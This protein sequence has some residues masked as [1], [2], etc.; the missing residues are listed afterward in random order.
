[1]LHSG[2]LPLQSESDR[3][4]DERLPCRRHKEVMGWLMLMRH[5]LMATQ[6]TNVMA[7]T[8][9]MN[10]R[11]INQKEWSNGGR[12]VLLKQAR[13][14]RRSTIKTSIQFD[15]TKLAK[16]KTNDEC[17]NLSIPFLDDDY[18]TDKWNTHTKGL[19]FD[20][21]R[22]QRCTVCYDI[23]WSE[24]RCM[25]M[26]IATTNATSRWKDAIQVDDYG[27]RAVAEYNGLQYWCQDWQ[28]D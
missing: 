13:R 22:G 4:G 26:S 27:F 3:D 5:R 14:S 1:M 12:N 18:D 28:S 9:D 20:P 16:K 10:R 21:E 6:L 19:E 15:G 24:L 17:S 7:S 23:E 11:L 8:K 2:Q 25:H